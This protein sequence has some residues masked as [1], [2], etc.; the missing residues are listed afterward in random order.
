M[1]SRVETQY[2]GFADDVDLTDSEEVNNVDFT[3]EL[4]TLL[5]KCNGTDEEKQK[6]MLTQ[7]MKDTFDNK[8]ASDEIEYDD[9][10]K[11]LDTVLPVGED[12]D[13]NIE[14]QALNA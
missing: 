1:I 4:K 7:F 6:Y 12:N 14:N 5:K 10:D 8:F 9:D 2:F 11:Q 3:V 13:D